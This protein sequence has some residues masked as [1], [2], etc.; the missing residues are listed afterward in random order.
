MASD[1]PDNIVDQKPIEDSKKRRKFIKDLHEARQE[2]AVKWWIYNIY[3]QASSV[4]AGVSCWKHHFNAY[5]L[6]YKSC[7]TWAIPTV[8]IIVIQVIPSFSTFICNFVVEIS[9]VAVGPHGET[10]V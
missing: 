2:G 9:F 7:W 6:I 4:V 10:L 8:L 5:F 3:L 1:V